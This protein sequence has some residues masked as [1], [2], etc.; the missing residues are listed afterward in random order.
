[1]IED[2]FFTKNTRWILWGAFAVIVALLIFHAGVVVGQH[3]PMRG[4][5]NFASG[6]PSMPDTGMLSGIMPR[7]GYVEDGHGAVGTIATVTLPTFTMQSRDGMEQKI[8]AGTS[9]VVT[10]GL[11]PDRSALKSGQVI[12]VVGDPD[13]TDDGYLEARI[14]HILQ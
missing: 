8:Y 10:G 2:Y 12:I 9:T 7:Q 5:M 4:R 3:Q 13:D 11:A 14:I 1:M 6:A